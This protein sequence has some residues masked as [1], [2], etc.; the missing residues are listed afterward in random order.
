MR[1]ILKGKL[2]LLSS[3]DYDQIEQTRYR[4]REGMKTSVRKGKVAGRIA[5]RY[6]IKLMYDDKGERI[7]GV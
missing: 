1:M 7:P 6:R 3:I 2:G 4:T 5:Y